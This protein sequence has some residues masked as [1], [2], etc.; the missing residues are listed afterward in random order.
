MHQHRAQIAA[1]TGT[2]SVQ[3]NWMQCDLPLYEVQLTPLPTISSH[4]SQF[5]ASHRLVEKA[6]GLI[7]SSLGERS[8]LAGEL[9]KT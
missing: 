6:A 7:L 3:G 5:A 1:T 2:K 4:G 9:D 8:P